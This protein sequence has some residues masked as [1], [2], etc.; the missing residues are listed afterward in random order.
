MKFI[1]NL[2]PA[3]KMLLL[4]IYTFI[5]FAVSVFIITAVK[6]DE[7]K[8]F[9]SQARDENIQVVSKLVESRTVGDLSNNKKETATWTISFQITKNNPIV[10]VSDIELYT[11]A[12]TEDGSTIYFEESDNSNTNYKGTP[13]ITN[14]AFLSYPKKTLDTKIR[15][16]NTYSTSQK[17][18][19]QASTQLKMVYVRILYNVKSGDVKIPQELKY[20]FVPT[21]PNQID[22]NSI[23]EKAVLTKNNEVKVIT[24]NNYY[25]ISITP[26]LDFT[27]PKEDNTTYN[28]K[29]GFSLSCDESKLLEEGKYV[30]NSSI[31]L[32][33]KVKNDASDTENY[34]DDYIT[35]VELHGVYANKANK[36]AWEE[37]VLTK[38]NV[39]YSSSC[40]M[41]V[42]YEVSE[43]YLLVSYTTNDG[44]TT[45]EN[46]KITLNITE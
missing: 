18:Y 22:F 44:H 34:F 5:L 21:K 41:N 4:I 42:T 3:Y 30:I 23:E 1:K 39:F 32:Y 29:I 37:K 33:A 38:L 27:N 12:E 8:G 45:F 17:A 7:D 25:S 13:S 9:K 24:D 14:S 28:D 15:K 20:Y 19:T 40:S 26:N 31:T 36:N 35:V 10:E 16:T 46:A 43:L 11:T 2:S 6:L